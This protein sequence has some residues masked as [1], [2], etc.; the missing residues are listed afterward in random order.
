[1][2]TSFF[3]K[4]FC[5]KEAGQQDTFDMSLYGFDDLHAAVLHARN[6][7][8]PAGKMLVLIQGEGAKPAV[9]SYLVGR[10][11]PQIEGGG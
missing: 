1:M 6:F 5:L 2:N 3:D 4:Q 9:F 8:K 7:P 10:S 11:D